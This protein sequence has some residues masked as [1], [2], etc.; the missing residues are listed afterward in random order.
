MSVNL[1]WRGDEVKAKLERATIIG[2]NRTM[3]R[4]VRHAKKHVPRQT[5]TL[6]RSIKIRPAKKGRN[7]IRGLWG[8][9]DVLYALYVEIGLDERRSLGISKARKKR[10]NRETTGGE[11]AKRGTANRF[12][13]IGRN[14]GN[15]RFLRNAADKF[16]PKLPDEIR[17]AFRSS[18]FGGL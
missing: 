3:A 15:T 17:R 1:D 4:S 11:R 5:G 8:S 16:Y 9:F 18:L 12:R 2:I 13:S 10:R 14:T 6:A 7:V